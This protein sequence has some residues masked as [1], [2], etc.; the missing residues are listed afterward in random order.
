[1]KTGGDSYFLQYP[2]GL[3]LLAPQLLASQLHAA[4][5]IFALAEDV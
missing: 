5:D 2:Q 4:G 1:M 3:S